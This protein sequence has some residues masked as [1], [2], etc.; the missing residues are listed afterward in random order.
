[1]VLF[2]GARSILAVVPLPWPAVKASMKRRGS[3]NFEWGSVTSGKVRYI[4]RQLP[5]AYRVQAKW[6]DGALQET[7]EAML[8]GERAIQGAALWLLSEDVYGKADLLVRS[9]DAPSDLGDFHYRVKEVKNAG[10]LKPYH[11]L[12]AAAYVW[13][14]GRYKVIR[15]DIRH[16]TPRRGG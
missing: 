13:I 1:M 4:A 11:Q 6:T 12:Q 7:L 15:G 8:R 14:L 9:D 16:R 5:D 3:T 2:Y 10:K